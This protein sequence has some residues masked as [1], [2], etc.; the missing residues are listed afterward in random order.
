VLDGILR[1]SLKA[2]RAQR[3]AAENAEKIFTTKDTKELTK[4]AKDR[5]GFQVS[6][7]AH[8]GKI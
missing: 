5:N 7:R 4:G 3:R 6:V 1:K 8:E 2:Q